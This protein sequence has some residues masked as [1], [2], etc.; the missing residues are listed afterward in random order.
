MVCFKSTHIPTSPIPDD[1][2]IS[3][4]NVTC[5]PLGAGSNYTISVISISN[6]VSSQMDYIVLYTI[7]NMVSLQA[8]S[9][10]TN[11]ITASWG[12]PAGNVDEYN[13]TCPDGST[14]IPTSPIPDDDSISLYNVTCSPLGA[15]SN[16]TISVISI[17]NNGSSEMDSIVLYTNPNMVS[18]QKGP[19]TTNSITA[20]WGSPAG[21]VDEYN[22]TCPDG[23]T[24]IPTS[25]IPDDDSI[26]LYNVTCSPLGA[27][28]NYTISVI[29]I[30]NNG[31]S[32]MD[33]IVL[34]TIPNMV[35]LQAESST[36]NSITA[37]WGSPAGKVNEYNV[38]CPTNSTAN[39]PSPIEA[40]GTTYMVTC[41]PLEAGT[42]YTIEVV[43]I[44]LDVSSEKSKH[45]VTNN[46]REF[47]FE[48]SRR[49]Y[50]VGD[51]IMG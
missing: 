29:S 6:N 47:D 28:S 2:S 10:T 33:S 26:S 50:H 32:E 41:S 16:Y 38:T 4:Y 25:P 1:D 43:T 49:K 30:S 14:A 11:S 46:T 44:S 12:S 40:D 13:V 35:S 48:G 34:Y 17:S 21:N 19:S 42:N 9:S 27:G 3:L 20:S 36:T 45:N 5:S 24:A 22:V 39:P 15:G 18:L 37:S 51:G 7:P 8:G 23:S 31:S